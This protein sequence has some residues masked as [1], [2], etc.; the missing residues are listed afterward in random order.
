M[1]EFQSSPINIPKKHSKSKFSFNYPP[2]DSASY[3]FELEI[4]F[5]NLEK[6]MFR[7]IENRKYCH[8]IE[9]NDKI[10]YK[11]LQ[12]FK[13]TIIKIPQ[14]DSP[15]YIMENDLN[16]DVTN[17]SKKEND[18]YIEFSKNNLG[19]TICTCYF[20]GIDFTDTFISPPN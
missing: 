20:A 4:T 5:N 6:K 1:S 9:I 19:L 14:R 17:F 13:V 2:S 7:K 11:D 18:I 15:Q 12:K 3:Y 16:K 10:Q 8:L